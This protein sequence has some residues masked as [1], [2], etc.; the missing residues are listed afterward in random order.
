MH[1]SRTKHINSHAA[2][3][4]ACLIPVGNDTHDG[5]DGRCLL[6]QLSSR[7]TVYGYSHLRHS[8]PG[9]MHRRARG[10][11]VHRLEPGFHDALCVHCGSHSHRASGVHA[12]QLAYVADP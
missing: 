8:D 5:Y 4:F 10:N 7:R 1:N 12:H 2:L 6:G 3:D 9:F 11:S